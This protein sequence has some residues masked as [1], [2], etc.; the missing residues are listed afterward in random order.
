MEN[1]L[2]T[3]ALQ[4]HT[5][6]QCKQQEASHV[7]IVPEDEFRP[8]SFG[9]DSGRLDFDNHHYLGCD[10]LRSM[11]EESRAH[12]AALGVTVNAKMPDIAKLYYAVCSPEQA[13]V[14]ATMRSRHIGSHLSTHFFIQQREWRWNT[15]YMTKAFADHLFLLYFLNSISNGLLDCVL[16]K[17][18]EFAPSAKLDGKQVKSVILE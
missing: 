8:S 11:Y 10:L 4:S 12:A 9:G 16:K 14:S 1:A 5:A 17:D 3:R 2:R 15:L 7:M 6:K 13:S 18:F